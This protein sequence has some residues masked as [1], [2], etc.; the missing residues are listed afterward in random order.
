MATWRA[1]A[2]DDLLTGLNGAEAGPFTNA[3]RASGQSN[4]VEETRAAVTEYVRGMVG[5]HNVLGVDDSIPVGCILHA[6]SI[7]RVR[8][9]SRLSMKLADI[10]M[11][12]YDAAN[13]FFA[14]VMK[15]TKFPPPAE[16]SADQA[17]GGAEVARS[18]CRKITRDSLNGL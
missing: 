5:M 10:R 14:A 1:L 4:P 7:W 13:A 9:A 3:V 15:G 17:G 18:N 6:V 8:A 12:E 11:K 2:N 16:A